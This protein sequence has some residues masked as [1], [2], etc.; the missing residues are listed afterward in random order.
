[1]KDCWKHPN[2]TLFHTVNEGDD[3]ISVQKLGCAHRP[4][5]LRSSIDSIEYR[6]EGFHT[7]FKN[8]TD[9]QVLAKV[10][11]LIGDFP[12]DRSWSGDEPLE[13]LSHKTLKASAREF[14]IRLEKEARRGIRRTT[15]I[16]PS[17]RTQSP[18]SGARRS[19]GRCPR[20]A[21]S[22]SSSRG[23][24]KVYILV[25]ISYYEMSTTV[26][27]R[28]PEKLREEMKK[29]NHIDWAGWVRESIEERIRRERLRKTWMEIEEIKSRIPMSPEPDFSTRSVR[30][31][32]GR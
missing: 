13:S 23:R 16:D 18:L 9:S 24:E 1:M 28:I 12:I 17:S 21:R 7:L 4:Q 19:G 5:N 11:K 30:E 22:P 20:R 26:S 27:F 25:N 31:D 6:E 29:L 15:T 32:R 2:I 3:V 14:R 8:K 10:R